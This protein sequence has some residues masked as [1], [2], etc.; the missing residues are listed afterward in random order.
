MG[1]H[2][3]NVSQSRDAVSCPFVRHTIEI[4]SVSLRFRSSIKG[5]LIAVSAGVTLIQ[6]KQLCRFSNLDNEKN[7]HELIL[8]YELYKNVHVSE[9]IHIKV[10][11][12]LTLNGGCYSRYGVRLNV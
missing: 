7:I 12:I 1:V 10:N 11:V 6:K 4:C 2:L 3:V 8:G 5:R 9:L